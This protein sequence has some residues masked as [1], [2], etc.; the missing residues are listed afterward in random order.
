[1]QSFVLI[2]DFDKN[3]I[4]FGEKVA[5]FGGRIVQAG[6]SEPIHVNPDDTKKE[7]GSGSSST[8][9]SNDTGTHDKGGSDIKNPHS[10]PW[11]PINPSGG[12]TTDGSGT[13]VG[14]ERP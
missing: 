6:S 14:N 7:D 13:D 5:G 12:K 9:S 10:E 2:L 4:G 1:M 8:S 3:R 11:D